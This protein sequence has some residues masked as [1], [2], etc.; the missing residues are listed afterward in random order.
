MNVMECDH[1]FMTYEQPLLYHINCP[2]DGSPFGV[3][4]FA[5]NPES[6][7]P[8][9]HVN[10][11]RIIHKRM[12]VDIDPTDDK[13]VLNPSH[14]VIGPEGVTDT[15]GPALKVITVTTVLSHP[16]ADVNTSV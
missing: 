14:I 9:G 1:L 15:D 8:S 3:Y 11:S 6:H 12:T 4:S 13:V 10:M 7:Y 5:Q 16:L 2:E